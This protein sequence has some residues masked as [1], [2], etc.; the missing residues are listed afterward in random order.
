MAETSACATALR[1]DFPG[2][3]NIGVLTIHVPARFHP[4][5][6]LLGRWMQRRLGDARRAE[7][8]FLVAL[9][10]I[11]L[12]MVLA[13]FMAWLWLQ[14]AILADPTGPVAVTFWLGQVGGVLLCL[15]TCVVGFTPAVDVI[16]TATGLRLRRGAHERTLSYA[17]I[18]S[19]ESIAA[20]R[21]YRHYGRY[22]ATDAFINRLTPHVLLLHTP[23]GPVALG[24]PPKDHDALRR[25]LEERRATVFEAPVAHV[26]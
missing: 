2:Q 20:L 19:V 17:E 8:L 23:G 5:H 21:Y 24:L 16:V 22:A 1:N 13:Q 15:C 14:G 25:H 9:S 4:A 26:A 6:S 12:G 10:M 7:A 3:R 11:L 18:T